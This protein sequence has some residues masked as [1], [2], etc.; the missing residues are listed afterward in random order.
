MQS[1]PVPG[2]VSLQWIPSAGT[3]LPFG[4]GALHITCCHLHKFMSHPRSSLPPPQL[5]G[6]WGSPEWYGH[7]ALS[8]L[9]KNDIWKPRRRGE[10]DPLSW[11]EQGKVHTCSDFTCPGSEAQPFSKFTTFQRIWEKMQAKIYSWGKP[12]ALKSGTQLF[13][14]PTKP[15]HWGFHF[16]TSRNGKNINI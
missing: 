15:R 5:C 2:K 3:L 16:H 6:L 9:E 12:Q 13:L 10:Q 7:F 1:L 14:S 11:N 4:V 8:F